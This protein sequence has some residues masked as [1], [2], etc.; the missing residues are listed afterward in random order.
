MSSEERQEWGT[1]SELFV[2]LDGEFHFTVDAAAAKSNRKCEAYWSKADCGLSH[3]W[4]GHSVWCNPPYK[5]ILPWVSKAVAEQQIHRG[6]SGATSVLLLPVRTEQAWFRL[7]LGYASEVA[8]F[9]R[10]I[11]FAPPRGVQ[12]SSNREASLLLVFGPGKWGHVETIR[13]S[14]TGKVLSSWDRKAS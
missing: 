5:G 12:A 1:P 3:S 14:I 2:S 4:R 10:R 7:A 8:Y 9:N 6:G 11:H 13:D